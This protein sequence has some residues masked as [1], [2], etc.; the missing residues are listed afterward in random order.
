MSKDENKC[1]YFLEQLLTQTRNVDNMRSMVAQ[2]HKGG[3]GS[4]GC[5]LNDRQ[6]SIAKLVAEDREF[7]NEYLYKDMKD[8]DRF[9]QKGLI[10]G[11]ESYN[12]GKNQ[13]SFMGSSLDSYLVSPLR[14]QNL[15]NHQQY[16][17]SDVQADSQ[18]PG[19]LR[20]QQ[21][22]GMH[23]R[24]F[25]LSSVVST[26]SLES[27]GTIA[28]GPCNATSMTHEERVCRRREFHNA[29]ERR[30]R[31]LIKSKIQQLGTL[32]PSNFL[33][34]DNE[35]KEVRL[36]KGIIL[37]R[38]VEYLVYLKQV[39]EAQ[40]HK[41]LQLQNIIIDL[42]Q[43]RQE[44]KYDSHRLQVLGQLGYPSYAN[45]GSSDLIIDTRVTPKIAAH[46]PFQQNDFH[47]QYPDGFCKSLSRNTIKQEDNTKLILGSALETPASF[48]LNFE[49]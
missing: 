20:N 30:R 42:D 12:S 35:G 38:T 47:S 46:E 43:R 8:A 6:T 29:V 22:K 37:H 3:F 1:D 25:S 31:E 2:E 19:P 13:K 45:S 40:E 28:G 26:P 7:L 11:S 49:P 10:G 9:C 4:K 41:R 36:N 18:V 16:L 44:L 15:Q 14:S 34:Y 24:H 48:L 33:N 27:F 21:V 32:V 39:L 23:A 5:I 17:S